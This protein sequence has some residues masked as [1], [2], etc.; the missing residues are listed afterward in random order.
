MK[1]AI[2]LTFLRLLPAAAFGALEAETA[3]TAAAGVAGGLRRTSSNDGDVTSDRYWIV[4]VKDV[5]L[6][7]IDNSIRA[8]GDKDD[9]YKCLTD[10]E[11]LCIEYEQQLPMGGK[12]TFGV[13]HGRAKL[14]NPKM[15]VVWEFC[16]D[17]THVCIGEEQGYD[18][19]RFSTQRPY[20]KFYNERT[21]EVVGYLACDGTD[22]KVRSLLASDSIRFDSILNVPTRRNGRAA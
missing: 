5:G 16:T 20:L 6:T 21:H 17:V 3:E 4:P 11:A 8:G 22:G 19:N 7:C 10:G 13:Q 18:P 12:W 14:W 1:L 9:E 15:E 2:A